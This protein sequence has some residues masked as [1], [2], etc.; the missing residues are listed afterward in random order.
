MANCCCSGQEAKTRSRFV[1]FVPVQLGP[2]PPPPEEGKSAITVGQ[3][4]ESVSVAAGDVSDVLVPNPQNMGTTGPGFS[5]GSW[6]YNHQ[7]LQNVHY[8][9]TS[10]VEEFVPSDQGVTFSIGIPG[11]VGIALGTI[12]GSNNAILVESTAFPESQIPLGEYQLLVKSEVDTTLT[13]L[14]VTLTFSEQ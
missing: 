11:F 2:V 14:L 5:L 8:S 3:F 4:Y 12:D 7:S 9:F 6:I 10:S 13:G 1:R